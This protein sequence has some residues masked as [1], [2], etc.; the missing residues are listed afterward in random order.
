MGIK[1]TG[2]LIVI[3]IFLYKIAITLAALIAVYIICYWLVRWTADIFWYYTD[4]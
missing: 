4:R 2:I 3:C 1:I